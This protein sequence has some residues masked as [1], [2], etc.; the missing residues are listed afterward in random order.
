MGNYPPKN[1]PPV[2]GLDQRAENPSPEKKRST[3]FQ[4]WQGSRKPKRLKVTYS[5]LNPKP[6]NP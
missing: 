1:Y 5:A 6:L 3:F 2:N 4:L